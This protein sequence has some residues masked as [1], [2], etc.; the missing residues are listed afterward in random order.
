MNPPYGPA[1]ERWLTKLADHGTGTALVFARTE[2]RAFF[3]AVWERADALLFLEGRQHFHHADGT[4][5]IENSGG[6]SVLIAYGA[7]DAERLL[8]SG[9]EGAVVGLRRPV[10]L[11]LAFR[12]GPAHERKAWTEVVTDVIRS[13]G[14]T[15]SLRALY[16]AL[17]AHPNAR[18]NPN[19]KAKVRQTC[20]RARLRKVGSGTYALDTAIAA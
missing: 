16:D 6:P 11:H 10:L 8:D 19:W 4:R 17:E 13:L 15:A 3:R 1:L 18:S 7:H 20:A 14:G 2:T 12:G 9:I 5:S